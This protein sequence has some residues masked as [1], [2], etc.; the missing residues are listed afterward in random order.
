VSYPFFFEPHFTRKNQ[1]LLWAIGL[2]VYVVC[3]G[4]CAI[5]LW[6]TE[7][8]DSKP[9]P[10]TGS[11]PPSFQNQFP[12]A[13]VQPP[14]R[15]AQILW[16][17]LP[18]CAS[19]LLLATT[20]KMCQD[21]AV[22]PFL[23]VLPL[24]LYLLSF[25]ICFDSPRWYVR[26]PFTLALIVASAGICWALFVG[27][28]LPIRKQVAIYSIGL[29]ICCMVCHGE[30][31]RLRPDPKF[32]TG[33]YLM[34]SAG[35][36]LGGMF[37]AVAAPLL[38]TDYYE[39]HW[40]LLMCSVLFLVVCALNSS[41]SKG[42]DSEP[43]REFWIVRLF[44][45][46][47]EWRLLGC[48]L[49]L[50]VFLGLDR[51]LAWLSPDVKAMAKDKF[52]NLIEPFHHVAAALD[53]LLA[54][55]GAQPGTVDSSLAARIAMWSL[56]ALL[57]GGWVI[58]GRF[59]AF[60]YWR[61]LTCLWLSLTVVGLGVALRAQ[62][63]KT[64]GEIVSRSR[65]F[66]GVLTVIEHE[67]DNP[68]THYFLLQHGRITHGI[69]FV[70]P[71]RAKWPT[72]YYGEDSGIAMA[73]EALPAGP[74]RIGVIGLG[75]GSITVYARP[76]D[77][78]RIYEINSQV[79]KLANSR[80]T[81]LKNSRDIKADVKVVLGDARLSLERE[82]SQQFD[83]LVLDAFSS[84]AIPVHLLTKESFEVY[85]KHLNPN[86]I[87]VVHISN[88]YLDLEPV[89]INLAKSFG[90]KLATVDYD[91]DEPNLQWW[92]YGSTWV[93]LSKNQSVIDTPS[94]HDANTD[95]AAST[96][97]FQKAA[98]VPLW[99]DDFTSLFQILK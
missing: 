15:V 58:S 50:V 63:L 68:K 86:G 99:T 78:V 26:F 90:F 12:E 46:S 82:P 85:Q 69:Q 40:S 14:S 77:S 45:A 22:I 28:E 13:S 34:I 31:Y 61:L 5:R 62:A 70:D 42:A 17:L 98:K 66:Y 36:A 95:H 65:N 73:F 76:G 37:V 10:A 64:D 49:P 80:F 7:T 30:L 72:S 41:K 48:T 4:F 57:A 92:L 32:L 89:V 43:N 54:R 88:R 91:E 81:Y 19:A 35:G 44:S 8:R 51:F 20:N 60:R 3:C 33:F 59:K 55:F 84:D 83:L 23:W 53:G 97:A 47:N 16:L 29:F 27:T 71:E 79:E 75:T 94:I 18:A 1:A 6:K 2:I 56:L 9:E 52:P 39:L 11:P 74:R 25:I 67:K 24:S 38:F 87:I 93:L 96:K 21:V